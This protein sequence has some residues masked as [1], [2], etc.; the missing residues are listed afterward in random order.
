MDGESYVFTSLCR[1]ICTAG[2]LLTDIITA[3]F[4]YRLNSSSKIIFNR[5][6]T[7]IINESEIDRL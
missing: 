4:N 7:K 1:H 2:Q 3:N 6:I 5:L